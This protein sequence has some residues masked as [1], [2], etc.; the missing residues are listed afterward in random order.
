MAMFC[1]LQTH[2]DGVHSLLGR[3]FDVVNSMVQNL[4]VWRQGLVVL[5]LGQEDTYSRQGQDWLPYH[6]DELLHNFDSVQ[7]FDFLMFYQRLG[8]GLVQNQY[9]WKSWDLAVQVLFEY[10]PQSA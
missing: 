8:L 4:R 10:R 2:Y 6:T 7:D 3:L 9:E 5:Q 1:Y